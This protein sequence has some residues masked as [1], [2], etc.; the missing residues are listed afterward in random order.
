MNILKTEVPNKVSKL[1][2]E[3]KEILM[4]IN[5]IENDD[6]LKLKNELLKFGIKENVNFLFIF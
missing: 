4:T 3:C 2:F 5:F 1:L 6:T